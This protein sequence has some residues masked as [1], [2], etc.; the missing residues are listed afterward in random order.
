MSNEPEYI[1]AEIVSSEEDSPREPTQKDS[2][3][4]QV[5]N[6]PVV[7]ETYEQSEPIVTKWSE[8]WWAMQPLHIQN[9]RCR[10]HSTRTGE[11]CKNLALQGATV[12]RFHGG[13]A[14]QV[15]AKAKVRLEMAADVVAKNLLGLALT[16][17]SETVQLGATNSA[18]DR[19]G[20]VKPTEVVLSQG[21]QAPYEEIFDG[22]STATR[23]ESRRDRGVEDAE[24]EPLES[25]PPPA[26][27][28]ADERYSAPGAAPDAY[29]SYDR[30]G[31]AD[32]NV[33]PSGAGGR[34]HRTAEGLR[35][36]VR[37][38]TGED[39]IQAAARAADERGLP[40]GGHKRYPAP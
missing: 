22:I 14:P 17:D 40:S 13:L 34:T 2:P 27:A 10:A 1:D 9:R 3:Q 30:Y 39:A 33:V 20:I 16:A 32:E 28:Y 6:L 15:K 12:C 21:S 25:Q 18:L 29:G 11:R 38:V 24:S 31:E 5:R 37:H 36:G 4:E 35:P 26:S 7:A 23:A 8:A 19:V